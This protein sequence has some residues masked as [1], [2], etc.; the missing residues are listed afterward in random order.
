MVR[1]SKSGIQK[2]YTFHET[3]SGNIKH[4]GWQGTVSNDHGIVIRG[5]VLG[6]RVETVVEKEMREWVLEFYL[7]KPEVFH[8]LQMKDV[9]DNTV[10][11]AHEDPEIMNQR[12][13]TTALQNDNVIFCVKD[14]NPVISSPV[15]LGILLKK[16]LKALEYGNHDISSFFSQL[17]ETY[18][19]ISEKPVSHKFR[20]TYL[21]QAVEQHKKKA[22]V[23]AVELNETIKEIEDS[24]LTSLRAVAE[25]LTNRKIP[26]A[27]GKSV[28]NAAGVKR[29]KQRIDNLN[30]K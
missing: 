6:S 27:N 5:S 9:I 10:S 18:S 21:E 13:I 30:L 3:H 2:E 25:E 16:K 23:K 29:I 19:M 28:W 11:I 8:G 14:L 22:D 1:K 4:I 7:H 20:G 17:V 24:G 12:L 15:S 26:T